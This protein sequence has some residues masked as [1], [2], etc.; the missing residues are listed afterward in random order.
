MTQFWDAADRMFA[1]ARDGKEDEARDADPA[2]AAGAAGGAQHRRGAAARAEQRG[3]GAGRAAQSR[4][5]TTSVQRQVYLFLAATLTAI[6]ADQPVPDPVQP[7]ALRA[8]WRR[9]PNSA[10]NWRRSSSRRRS[11]R[12]R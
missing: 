10:A 7:A 3:R 1:L 12:L 2:V 11:P 4:A 5:S 6:A 9:F 8:S